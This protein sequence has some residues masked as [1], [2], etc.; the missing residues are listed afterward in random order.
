LNTADL[1]KNL[2]TGKIKGA[3]LDVLEFESVSFEN[4][5]SN[6]FPE[7]MQYLV[8]ADNVILSPHIGGWTFESNEKM[9]KILAEKVAQLFSS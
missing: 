3:C 1:V 4:F 9:A 5:S 6:D 2:K 8:K 7:P